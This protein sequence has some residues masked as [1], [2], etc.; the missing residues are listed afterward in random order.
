MNEKSPEKPEEQDGLRRKVDELQEEVDKLKK[1]IMQMM[2]NGGASASPGGSS[3]QTAGEEISSQGASV[4]LSPEVGGE[5]PEQQS[6]GAGETAEESAGAGG[7]SSQT[8]EESAGAGGSSSQTAEA[9]AEQA[10]EESAEQDA[11]ASA[12]QAAE[13]SA[14]G[15]YISLTQEFVRRRNVRFCTHGWKEK[16]H[17]FSTKKKLWK[18]VIVQGNHIVSEIWFFAKKDRPIFIVA[19]AAVKPK[20]GKECLDRFFESARRKR[21]TVRCIFH[22]DQESTV[23]HFIRKAAK[24]IGYK[25]EE[26]ELSDESI[27]IMFTPPPRVRNS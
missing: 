12:E 8:A 11:E 18:D 16:I 6:A 27:H 15:R 4:L 25:R 13:E 21:Q 10:A 5:P 23:L 2:Q 7:N 22:K 24:D 26:D 19:I 14:G 3:S 17:A 20:Y 1:M 9:S